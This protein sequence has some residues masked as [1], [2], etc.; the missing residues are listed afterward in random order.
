MEKF[1]KSRIAVGVCLGVVSLMLLL[2]TPARADQACA[3]GS[4][5]TIQ[6]TQ[7]NVIELNGVVVTVTIDNTGANTKISFQLT[8]DPVSNT[9]LGID[10]VGWQN[11]EVSA[12][13]SANWHDAG[14]GSMD[15][16]GQFEVQSADSASTDGISSPVTFT[17]AGKIT[18]FDDNNL[19]NEFA[20]HVRY[21]GSCSG[22]VGGVSPS[23]PDMHSDSGC[24]PEVP[25]PASLTLLGSGLLGLGTVLRK[26]LGK[27]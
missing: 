7:T 13:P 3:N 15:G 14:D 9:P 20:V 6:L 5:C 2:G 23:G 26:R 22:F 17:L 19:A 24:S 16:F 1:R 27:K 18:N 8:A 10:Q 4:T 25:E 11:G 21:G 12:Y